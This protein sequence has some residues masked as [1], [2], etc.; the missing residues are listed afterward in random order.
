MQKVEINRGYLD[1]LR[2]VD[3]SAS[4]APSVAPSPF[5]QAIAKFTTPAIH[6]LSIIALFVATAVLLPVLYVI[7]AFRGR[8]MD[9]IHADGLTNVDTFLDQYPFHLYPVLGKALELGFLQKQIARASNGSSKVVELAIGDGSLSKTIYPAGR[10]IV[11]VEISPF[12]LQYSS[13]MPHVRKG[14][15]SDCV[16]PAVASGAFDLLVTNNF[17]HHVSDKETTL[18]HIARI[19]ERSIFNDNTTYW[20]T[21]W[22]RPFLLGK[23]GFKDAAA[24]ETD[25]LSKQFLQDLR[26]KKELDAMVEKRFIVEARAEY[27]CETTQFLCGI[28]SRLM[29]VYGPATPGY[30]KRAAKNAIL[31]PLVRSCTRTLAFSLIRFDNHQD[32]EK[33]IIIHYACRSRSFKKAAT[34]VEFACAECNTDLPAD[35]KCTACGTEFPSV[36]GMAFLLPKSLQFIHDRYITETG[37]FYEAESVHE[38]H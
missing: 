4:V 9:E 29:G 24:R 27:L 13:K 38:H 15:I 36:Q 21:S 6:A 34:P 16:N 18:D 37:Q 10:S 5:G 26:P 19:A 22:P 30:V 7:N 25:R 31:G 8:P 32:K 17:L 28:F 20:S 23:F 35:L 3:P 1:Y 33:A 2:P 12:S 14:A 11:A